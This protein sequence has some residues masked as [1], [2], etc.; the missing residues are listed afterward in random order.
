MKK[1]VLLVAV[2]TSLLTGC[3]QW[4]TAK[5]KT[6]SE[7]QRF[8]KVD[9]AE[10]RG[11]ANSQI[12]NVQVAD[13]GKSN[14]GFMNG[15]NRGMNTGSAMRANLDREE[16]YEACMYRRGWVTDRAE[17]EQQQ[18]AE[19][20]AKQQIETVLN[21]FLATHPEYRNESKMNR[22]SIE[23]SRLNNDPAN[24]GLSLEQLL[25]LAD[26]RIKAIPAS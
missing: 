15:V 14:S 12:Q 4:Y 9:K 19:A 2:S 6:E 1:L 13:P 10:C 25:I 23:V 26:E 3:T 21:S 24:K 8:L 17:M 20:A 22:L 18:R 16:L 11:M 7:R 5:Y